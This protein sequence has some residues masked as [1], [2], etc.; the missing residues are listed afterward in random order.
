MNELA[1]TLI[2]AGYPNL[3]LFEDEWLN[4]MNKRLK[5][6]KA[7]S[8]N[9]WHVL[10]ASLWLLPL[11]ALALQFKG[12]KWTQSFLQSRLSDHANLSK[13]EDSSLQNQKELAT[14]RSVARMVSVASNYGPYRA[15][16]LKKS[17]V[18]CSLLAR[19]GIK[20][21]LRIGV[22]NDSLDFKAHAWVEIRG[23]HMLN[24][25]MEENYYRVIL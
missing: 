4:Y 8:T 5:Q 7:L 9:E 11:T 14:A 16:C 15:N 12:F 3:D 13:D 1:S 25:G 22:N 20:T 24:D 23:M 18:T 6:L 19:R 17:L 21:E 2:D 10:L